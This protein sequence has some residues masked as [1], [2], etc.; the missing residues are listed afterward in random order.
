VTAPSSVRL[1]LRALLPIAALALVVLVI[2]FVELCG[3]ED[4]KPFVSTTPFPTV[5]PQTPVDTFTPGP[6]PTGAAPAGT[7]TPAPP[8]EGAEDRDTQRVQDL[9]AI[10]AALAQYLDE[11][12]E[13]PNA[14]G[15]VQTLC[16]FPDSDAGCQLSEVLSP[17]P[18]DPL[19]EPITENGY[20][21][22]S[23]EDTYTVFAQR[24]SDAFQECETHPEFL[25]QFDTLL[26]VGSPAS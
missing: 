10:Q 2:I 1:D 4:V 22:T 24:E 21:F 23:T 11:N 6:S 8:A 12:G 16:A 5:P 20:W 26:C 3:R 14:N 25:E 15:N 9:Q 19:G 13:Y 17:L 18:L 7:S